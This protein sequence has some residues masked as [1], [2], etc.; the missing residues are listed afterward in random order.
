MFKL[1][2]NQQKMSYA[3]KVG[4][5]KASGRASKKLSDLERK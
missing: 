5:G 1:D 2:F 3:Y 4:I